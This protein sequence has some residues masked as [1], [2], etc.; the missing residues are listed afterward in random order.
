MDEENLEKISEYASIPMSDFS[1]RAI[2][3]ASH[4]PMRAP[5]TMRRCTER[6]HIPRENGE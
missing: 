2:V 6:R 4:E 1:E 3:R 5:G